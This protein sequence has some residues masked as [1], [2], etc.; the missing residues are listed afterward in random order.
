MFI[1]LAALLSG[2]IVLSTILA[3]SSFVSLPR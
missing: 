1:V 3:A 2:I